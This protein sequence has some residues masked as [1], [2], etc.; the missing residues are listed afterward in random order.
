M[1]FRV[2]AVRTSDLKVIFKS[3]VFRQKISIKLYCHVVWSN[4]RLGFGMHIILVFIDHLQIETT[5]KYNT[6][7]ISTLYKSR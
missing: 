5:N 4:Y 7:A 2:I 3:L 1:L 6:I